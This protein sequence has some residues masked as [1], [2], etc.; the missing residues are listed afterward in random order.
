[1]SFVEFLLSRFPRE[2]ALRVG[3]VFATGLCAASGLG[4][5]PRDGRLPDNVPVSNE[6][7]EGARI[8]SELAQRFEIYNPHSTDDLRAVKAMGFDQVIL[9]WPQLHV[10]ASEMGLDVVM[11]NWWTKDTSAEEIQAGIDRAKAVDPRFL[12][13]V[14]M[15]DEP[16]RHSPDTPFSFYRQ[17]YERLRDELDGERSHVLVEISHWG[18]L[19]IWPERAYDYFVPLYQSADRIRIM[20]YPDLFENPLNEVYYMM[21]RSRRVMRLAGRDLPQAVILQTWVLPPDPKLPTLAELRVMVYQAMLAGA[22]TI[23]F[24]NYDPQTWQQTEGFTEGFAELMR[25]VTRFRDRFRCATV[26][27]SMDSEGILRSRLFQP[28][29]EEVE[30]LVNTN[31]T[32]VGGLAA[33]EVVT[34]TICE[35]CQARKWRPM[36]RFRIRR[37]FRGRW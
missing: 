19:H 29:G 10:E 6:V 32:S 17:Q 13:A 7:F 33:L 24:F 21:L 18:P 36:C 12:S 37:L 3:I 11:A 27:T 35:P 16:E 20:P 23:S 2:I 1:M 31:R 34:R 25:E 28:N 15:M 30:V 4:A 8:T 14:S 9:D 22:D 26:H 5:E